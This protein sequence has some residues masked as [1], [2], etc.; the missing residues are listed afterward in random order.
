[1]ERYQGL[2]YEQVLR[3]TS[4]VIDSISRTKGLA[5]DEKSIRESGDE[6]NYWLLFHDFPGQCF[7]VILKYMPKDWKRARAECNAL[8]SVLCEGNPLMRFSAGGGDLERE[9]VGKG[10]RRA[11]NKPTPN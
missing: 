7:P 5:Y 9:V 6:R 11:L 10:H 1:M 2:T 8:K 4:S 3:V